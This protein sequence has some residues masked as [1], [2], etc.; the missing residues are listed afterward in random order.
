LERAVPVAIGR[1]ENGG[2]TVTY[3][4]V[5]RRWLKLSDWPSTA[6]T[7]NI[8]LSEIATGGV[9]AAAVLVQEGTREKPGV[10]LGAGIAVIGPQAARDVPPV[11]SH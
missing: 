4:N 5:V 8:P 3:H 10:I 11:A 6:S 7:W 2:Q 9:N 1:G